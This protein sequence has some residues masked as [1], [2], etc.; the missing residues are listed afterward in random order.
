MAFS[1]GVIGA[2]MIECLLEL[3]DAQQFEACINFKVLPGSPTGTVGFRPEARW[4]DG[5]QSFAVHGAILSMAYTTSGKAF[6]A[7]LDQFRAAIQR[8]LADVKTAKQIGQNNPP[9]P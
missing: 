2:A 7:V 3:K 9:N 5:E 8:K 6:P 1:I 4:I